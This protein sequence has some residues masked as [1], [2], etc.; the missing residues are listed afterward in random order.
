MRVILELDDV[1]VTRILTAL[2][3][4][5]E[6][7]TDPGSR[8]ATLTEATN[9]ALERLADALDDP[10]TD[11]V[12][13]LSAAE[14]RIAELTSIASDLDAELRAMTDRPIQTP[15]GQI[16][17]SGALTA[18]LARN[19][20][21]ESRLVSL[22][23]ELHAAA[24]AR[25]SAIAVD[26]ATAERTILALASTPRDAADRPDIRGVP[27]AI[28][29]PG[30][31]WTPI[32]ALDD[33]FIEIETHVSA[34]IDA[35]VANPG[36]RTFVSDRL[37]ATNERYRELLVAGA[38]EEIVVIVDVDGIPYRFRLSADGALVV[39]PIIADPERVV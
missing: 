13:A 26:E 14:S 37:L 31:E 1:T 18:A 32:G 11:P 35:L 9:I 33:D 27:V 24:A 21:L 2:D 19:A 29:R 25:P 5:S 39:G 6:L 38:A 7:I 4:T 16:A 23:T 12:A 34:A 30:G 17:P 20:E 22:N 10:D 36:L 3:P 28:W 8:T 15:T